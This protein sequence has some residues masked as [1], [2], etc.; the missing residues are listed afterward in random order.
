MKKN[1]LKSN[2]S[3]SG[4]SA[5]AEKTPGGSRLLAG[6]AAETASPGHSPEVKICG[7]TRVDE[8]VKCAELGANAVGLV[9]YP[10]SPRFV[11]VE[12]AR[13]I[14]RNLPQGVC[15]VG[16][17]VNENY[18]K[19]VE[20][21]QASGLKAVQLHGV[22]SPALVSLLRQAGLTVIKSLF[23]DAEPSVRS[24]GRY[25]ASACLV[26][27]APGQLPGGNGVAWDWSA[28]RSV[29][30]RPIIL[31]GG[32][33]PSNVARAIREA[34]PDAVDVSSGVEAEPGR[35]DPDKV[36]RFINAVCD[37]RFI[38]YRRVFK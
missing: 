4:R 12:T 21:V 29:R 9:F 7:L 36:Q 2:R 3:A 35:K 32:L 17:F 23:V 24:E 8:A 33:N 20:T 25:D 6:E 10:P 38:T 15:G 18:E 5:E 37:S 19:I 1:D 13:D 34:S 16:V 22:E 26:E 14:V 31:A 27:C 28:V 11:T 30:V